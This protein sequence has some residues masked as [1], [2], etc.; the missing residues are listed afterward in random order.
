MKQRLWRFTLVFAGLFAF[1][2]HASEAPIKD[3]YF[4]LADVFELEYV[5]DPQ[6]SPDGRLIAYVRNYMDVMTDRRRTE[7][8]VINFDGT[9][10]RPVAQG[11]GDF[12]S[13]RWSPDGRRLLYVANTDGSRQIYSRWMDA[14]QVAKLSKLT[15]S[16]SNITWSPDGGSIAFSMRVKAKP[17]PYVKMPDKPE[18]AEWAKPAKFIDTL[19]YRADGRGFLPSGFN[20]IFVLPSAGGTPRQITHGEFNHQ[21]S[22]SWSADSR[23]IIFSANRHEDWQYDPLNSEVYEASIAGRDI[24]ALTDRQGPDA[25][26]VVS[27]DGRYIAYLGFDDREQGYQVTSVYLMNR[28]GDNP[29]RLTGGLDRS[30]GDLAWSADSRGI[31]FKY[32]DQGDT[33]LAY[34]TLNGKIETLAENLGGTSIGRPYPGS[35]YS[36]ADNGWFAFTR[37]R[38]DRPAD[39]AIGSRRGQGAKSLTAV[40]EDL[41]AYKTLGDVEEIWFASSYDNRRVQGWIIKPPNFDANKKYPLILEIHGGPFA[42]YGPRFSTELQLYATAG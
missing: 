40:N 24:K 26:A 5:S 33:K 19:V 15:S 4:T 23:S 28:N 13:P 36:V 29:R 6:I 2:S 30:A 21:G 27:P 11:A 35:S 41:L 14:G 3:Q 9:S 17:K 22:I 31:Y 34:V 39:I 10:N 7:I 12:S 20:Q 18:G 16:P 32:D 25:G 38:S 42:N 37:V 1:A 8:W